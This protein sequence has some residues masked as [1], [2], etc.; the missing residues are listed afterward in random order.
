MALTGNKRTQVRSKYKNYAS[1]HSISSVL[2]V[3]KL[4]YAIMKEREHPGKNVW[5]CVKLNTL[6][7]QPRCSQIKAVVCVCFVQFSSVAQSCP[8]LWDPMDCSTPSLPLHYRLPESTQT[9]VHWVSDAIQPSHPLSSP[10]P[11]SIFPSIRVYSNES[12]LL[13]TIGISA[14]IS[15]F[16]INI[17]DWYPL[18]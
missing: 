15:V 6:K 13:Q 4:K 8:T 12:A 2:K 11:P 10:A 17:Q 16:P 1:G 18:G 3:K 5:Y 9:H 14:S 7:I